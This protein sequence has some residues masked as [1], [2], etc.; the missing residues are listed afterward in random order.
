MSWAFRINLAFL[1]RPGWTGLR[2]GLFRASSLSATPALLKRVKIGLLKHKA[3]FCTGREGYGNGQV[4]FKFQS[5]YSPQPRHPW[6]SSW[7]TDL[8][9]RCLWLL[10]GV[11][12]GRRPLESLMYCID[13]LYG[14]S[15]L[16]CSTFKNS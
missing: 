10:G 6:E 15:P 4:G 2:N 8:W 11:R 5:L 3:A 1:S 13:S 7:T 12:A 14:P 9:P 16:A